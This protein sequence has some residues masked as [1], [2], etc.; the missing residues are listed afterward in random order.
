MFSLCH[1]VIE[2]DYVH[3]ESF[4]QTP[5][6]KGSPNTHSH[7]LTLHYPPHSSHLSPP[8]LSL[9]LY[10]F[11]RAI[12]CSLI[13][14]RCQVPPF[15]LFPPLYSLCFKLSQAHSTYWSQRQNM[16]PGGQAGD[17]GALPTAERNAGANAFPTLHDVLLLRC[18]KITVLVFFSTCCHSDEIILMFSK[19]SN[20]QQREV[21]WTSSLHLV[22]LF[23]FL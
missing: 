13:F 23:Y 17:V 16:T 12:A 5:E 1:Y 18:C 19:Q 2:A 15:L 3:A 4:Y 8:P 21:S 20:D 11:N 22:L 14:S 6:I 9:S 7:T 10:P